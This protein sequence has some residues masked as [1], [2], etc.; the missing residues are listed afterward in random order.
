[1]ANN[2]LDDDKSKDEDLHSEILE[3]YNNLRES[4]ESVFNQYIDDQWFANGRQWDD[5]VKAT[6]DSQGL[7]SLTYNQILS[8]V[9]YIVNNA[10]GNTPAIK[11]NPVDNNA[12]KNTAKIYDGIIKHIQYK[13][14]AKH[15]YINALRDVVIGGIGA[16][17]ILPIQTKEGDYDIS[18][19]RIMDPTT[20]LIDA[21]STLQ[22]FSDATDGF[23][24]SWIP[25][26]T[27][28]ELYD[29]EDLDLAFDGSY[30]DMFSKDA[31]QVLEYW[32][33]NKETGYFEQFVLSG[34]KILEHNKSYRGKYLPIIF[35]TG[36]E[37]NIE[38]H[39]EYKGIVRDIKDM[40]MLLNLAKSRTADYIARSSNQQWLITNE[41]IGVY[42][43]I[44]LNSNVNG[45]PV[46]PYISTGA[47]APQ[48][49]DPPSPPVGFQAVS[50]EADADLRAAIGIRDPLQD[51]PTT[52]SGKAIALQIS[53]GNIGTYE[54]NYNL[55]E[56]I[57]H[58]GTVL[59][60]LIPH[61]FSYPHIREI[62]GLDG[63]VSTV[64][65]NQP[66]IDNGKQVMHDL[67]QGRYSVLVSDGP[68]YESQRE[69][70]SDKLMEIVKAEPALLNLIGDILFRNMTFDGSN[71]IADRLKANIPP[72]ILAASSQDNGDDQIKV[73]MAQ[74]QQALQQAQ[75]QMQQ[76]QQQNQQL[77]QEK[78]SKVAEIQ[79]K[80]HADVF[81]KELDHKH[82]KD[83]LQMKINATTADIAHKT[84]A[85]E[86]VLET[87]FE[88]ENKM[89]DKETH[90]K[91]FLKN[92]DSDIK[93]LL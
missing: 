91:I 72:N 82:E 70:A 26:K 16:W 51:I 5:K 93:K 46:L 56:A 34:S 4:W 80:A 76:L 43:D 14:N 42:K 45:I 39:R 62:M 29:D 18:I 6:R 60:D 37:V 19:Q 81:Q 25:K 63:Q 41:Q 13:Y 2:M 10:R 92:M 3:R 30:K 68:T 15:A 40:Q 7:S 1:M 77:M 66:Y 38:G 52:Q 84:I 22:D 79:E 47:G 85:E 49:L 24:D 44:W 61:Y 67:S 21:D 17:K 50:S 53:Q 28:E 35:M 78:Q 33:L 87:N 75:Q 88:L 57:K 32:K 89:H 8:K 65:L 36:T 74:M 90:A 20:V 86:D 83:M 59:L 58:T 69:E 64:P 11:V 27:Y 55:N 73:Q 9:N 31:V 12:D 54:Y 23:I 48:R 71:E